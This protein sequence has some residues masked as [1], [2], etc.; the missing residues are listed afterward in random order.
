MHFYIIFLDP[1]YGEITFTALSK[2]VINV[3]VAK[4]RDTGP[5]QWFTVRRDNWQTA[6][7]IA[8]HGALDDCTDWHARHGR[9]LYRIGAKY[10]GGSYVARD[11]YAD[12]LS[13]DRT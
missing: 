13:E 6:C 3:Q 8:V 1:P 12:T 7:D 4:G 2:G 9:N 10:Q 5:Y 11:F